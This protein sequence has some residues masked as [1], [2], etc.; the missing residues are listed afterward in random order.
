MNCIP[1]PTG[2][3][4]YHIRQTKP[5]VSPI[6]CVKKKKETIFEAQHPPSEGRSDVDMT[7]KHYDCDYV[8]V[9]FLLVIAYT[10]SF[11]KSVGLVV[12]LL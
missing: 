4:R 9:L 3:V 12:G 6:P 11:L 5:R 8:R 7:R 1:P 10:R 2:I